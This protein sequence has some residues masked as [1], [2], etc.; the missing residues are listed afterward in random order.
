MKRIKKILSVMLSLVMLT[1]VLPLTTFAS[2][3]NASNLQVAMSDGG[4]C[5]MEQ[6][7]NSTESSESFETS[8]TKDS[9]I[10]LTFKANDG[11]H[12]QALTVN[13]KEKNIP[14]DTKEYTF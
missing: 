1:S 5:I 2:E 10:K 9:T 14:N 3:E 6:D 8:L 11:Y 13:D 7:G 4:S 12:V